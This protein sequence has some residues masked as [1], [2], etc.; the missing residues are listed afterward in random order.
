MEIPYLTSIV[1]GVCLE[2]FFLGKIFFSTTLTPAKVIFNVTQDSIL[3]YSPCIYDT[4]GIK[5]PTMQKMSFSMLCA[6][7]MFFPLL[8][9]FS[10]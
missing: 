6:F 3:A 4:S 7:Y 9:L 10:R 2:G 8:A 5:E 1:V